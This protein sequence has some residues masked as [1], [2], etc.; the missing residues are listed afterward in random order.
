MNSS[1]VRVHFCE[2][3][4]GSK[5]N[6]SGSEPGDYKF[7][8]IKVRK[9]TIYQRT[10]KKLYRVHPSA[11]ANRNGLIWA[12]VCESRAAAQQ[13]SVLTGHKAPWTGQRLILSCEVDCRAEAA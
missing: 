9:A 6:T 5:E 10:S 1:E 7:C 11:S 13:Y 8:G 3:A 4:S 2:R 12:I